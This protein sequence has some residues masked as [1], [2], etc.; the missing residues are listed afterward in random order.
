MLITVKDLVKRFGDL[1]AL[2]H[3]NFHL[4]E[5]EILGLL[6]PNGSGKTTLVNCILGILSAEKGTIEIFGKP[7]SPTAY[8]IKAN[9]GLVPQEIGVLEALTVRENVD[10]FCGLYVDDAAKRKSMVDDA[11]DF[12]ELNKYEKFLPK[13]LSGGLKRRLNIACGIA[14]KPKL[15]FLDEPTVAVDAQS[16]AFILEGIKELNRHGCSV[17]YTTHYL[18]EVEQIC[19]RIVIMD[20]G[21]NLVDGTAD[22]LKE[23]IQVSEKIHAQIVNDDDT[24]KKRI[25]NIPHVLD[26]TRDGDNYVVRFRKSADN[27]AQ[28]VDFLNENGLIYSKIYTELPSLNDVFLEL[29]GKGLRDG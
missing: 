17:V 29:T 10:Y 18:E 4:K 24:V 7:M 27:L 26:V 22:E 2:D 25:E 19:T 5:G 12:V 14:H 13:K 23:M 6:G 28:F 1:V 21:K 11:L 3:F 9:I 15:L 16:R 20:K 8:D